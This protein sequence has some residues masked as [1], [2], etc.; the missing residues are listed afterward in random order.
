VTTDSIGGDGLPEKDKEV[1]AD[2]NKAIRPGDRGDGH[3]A[4]DGRGHVRSATACV[5]LLVW[6]QGS[7]QQN[8]EQLL[9]VFH[10][11]EWLMV[12]YLSLLQITCTK[13][14][15][16]TDCCYS[17]RYKNYECLLS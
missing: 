13:Q 9:L 16:P 11:K 4:P 3:V 1:A 12:F 7:D 14:I 6:P 2:N 5:S 15:T 17:Y 10:G 8:L